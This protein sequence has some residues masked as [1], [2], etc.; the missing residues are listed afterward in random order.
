MPEPRARRPHQ[1][2]A[3][4][5]LVLA[6]AVAPAA[7]GCG[8]HPA[9]SGWADPDN[10]GLPG[11]VRIAPADRGAVPDVSGP[12]VSGGRDGTAR[13]RGRILVVNVWGSLCGPC[14][15]EAPGLAR[16]ARDLDA[17][18]VSFLGV[19][20]RDLSKAS[21]AAFER[22]YGL[23]YPSLYDPRGTLLLRFPRGSLAP[24]AIPATLVLDRQGRIAAHYLGALDEQRLRAMIA[25]VLAEQPPASAGTGNRPS[26]GAP[27]A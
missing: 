26:G 2:R 5:L 9:A 13:H 10:A 3:A 8:G 15:V 18:G 1:L 16:V 23:P 22:R 4:A 12:T 21:A 17:Q 27:S 6:L 24:Q 25:P 20:S 14:R 11:P 7:T 19:D